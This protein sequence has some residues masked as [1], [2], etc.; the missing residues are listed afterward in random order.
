MNNND[1]LEKIAIRLKDFYP[2][3]D[4][5][6]FHELTGKN[7]WNPLAA[8]TFL[9]YITKEDYSMDKELCDNPIETYAALF[10]QIKDDPKKFYFRGQN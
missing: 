10:N 7:H 4:L 8:W 5:Q 9:E 2:T 6:K 3:K 1:S